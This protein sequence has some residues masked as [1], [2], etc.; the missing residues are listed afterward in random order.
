LNEKNHAI[1][2]QFL[3]GTEFFLPEL[4]D[5][6]TEGV[7]VN[8]N[9]AHACSV[10]FSGKHRLLEYGAS[11]GFFQAFVTTTSLL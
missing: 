2:E 3:N 1:T 8:F 10:V 4:N 6:L 9:L 5:I 11:N 7:E